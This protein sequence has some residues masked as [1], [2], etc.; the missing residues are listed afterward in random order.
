MPDVMFAIDVETPKEARESD[1]RS[2]FMWIVGKPPNIVIEIVSDKR[3]GEDSEK[4][5]SYEKIGVQYY[6]IYDP[7]LVLEKGTL[8][9]FGLFGG[10]YRQMEPANFRL[11]GL[12]LKLWDGEF[13]RSEDTWLR[14]IDATSGELIT[15]GKELA[16]KERSRAD[17]AEAR[18]MK[19]EERLRAAGLSTSGIS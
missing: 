13:E 8:R 11:F 19:L 4:L 17:A 12:A 5:R 14:W 2:Y 7:E 15:T 18:A 10:N 9:A 3:G 6:L 1:N 16:E